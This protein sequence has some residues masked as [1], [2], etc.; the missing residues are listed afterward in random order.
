MT[1][2][3]L[4][5]FGDPQPPR[6]NSLPELYQQASTCTQCRLHEGRTQVTWS[7]GDP[8][9]PLAIIGMGPSVTDDQTGLPYTGPAGEELDDLLKLVNLTR[10]QVYLTNA[11]KCVA[12]DKGDAFNIRTPTQSEL[13]ACFGW[14]EGEVYLVRPKLILCIGAPTA[15]WVIRKNFDLAAQHGQVMTSV[16]G[17]PAMATYQPTYITRLKVHDPAKAEEVYQAMVADMQLAVQTAGLG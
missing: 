2:L 12:R 6:A 16:F 8:Q 14:L 5:G 17:H 9:S 1:N 4:P 15:Q 7:S 10:S 13:K 11:H 3:M